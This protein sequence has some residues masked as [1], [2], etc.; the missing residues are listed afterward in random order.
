LYARID[1][2]SRE[3]L[4]ELVKRQYKEIQN[5]KE[6]NKKI[7]KELKKYKNPHTPSSKRTFEKTE[8][9]GL[10]VGRKKG[11]KTGHKGR[12]RKKDKPTYTV[13]VTADFN[14]KTGNKNIKPTGYVEEITITDF[15]I[16]KV[17]TKYNC[18]E[19]RDLDTGEIFTAR[20][21]D[22]PERGIF[23]KNVLAF[24][25]YLR[26]EGRVMYNKIASIF[27]DIIDVPMT[28]PTAMD[29]CTRVADKA[30]P[31]YENL[32][33]T[34]KKEKAVNGDETSAKRN[35]MPGWLWGFFSLTL[36]LFVFHKKRGGDIVQK[37]LGKDFKG[38]LGSDGWST[39]K[40]FC[41][42]FGILLQRCWAHAIREVKEVC[43]NRKRRNKGLEKA[44][45]WFCDIFDRVKEARKVKSQEKREQLY[46]ELIE[47]LDRWIQVYSTYRTLRKTVNT[48]KN[49]KEYWFTCVLH[50]EIEPTNNL[51]E[52]MLRHWV[53]FRKIIGCLRSEKGEQT[54]ETMLSLFGTWKL[55]GLHPYMQLKSLLGA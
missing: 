13:E 52:R 41:E 15:E 46:M 22:M 45:E 42:E 26:F 30:R 51:A 18:H 33:K 31:K 20:H 17:V 11:N 1:D 5:L 19:Y 34:I 8:V 21:Q 3:E 50:T 47:E 48:I 28:T 29:I 44:Y 24:A 16:V 25:S 4:I 2:L 12:T 32:K 53:V 43:M 35:G 23:G 27:T 10:K 39:Y 54:T 38:V 14:P 6:E 7:Q 40:V 37:I 49:G 55:R 9:L 36:A